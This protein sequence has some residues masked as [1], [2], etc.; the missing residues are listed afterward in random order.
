[1]CII[2]RL[3]LVK[4]GKSFQKAMLCPIFY[5]N[6]PDYINKQTLESVI[7]KTFHIKMKSIHM[8]YVVSTWVFQ[9]LPPSSVTLVR[10]E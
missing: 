5:F 1:M 8:S 4:L 10:Q 2:L 7:F 6:T 3:C 9:N